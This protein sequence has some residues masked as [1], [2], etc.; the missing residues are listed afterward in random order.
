MGRKIQL[1]AGML[2]LCVLAA[3][4]AAAGP[5]VVWRLPE[6]APTTP[7]DLDAK[8]GWAALDADGPKPASLP[9]GLA[10]EGPGVLA[11]LPAGGR[12]IELLSKGTGRARYVRQRLALVGTGGR[13]AGPLGKLRLIERDPAAAAEVVEKWP[14]VT[15]YYT[16]RGAAASVV[17]GAWAAKAPKAAV[18]WA[19]RLVPVGDRLAA[20]RA[21]A[22]AWAANA[23]AEAHAWAAARRDR[24]EAVHALVGLAAGLRRAAGG[25]VTGPTARRS[26][27][28]AP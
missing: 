16:Y 27:P 12:A 9:G 19:S 21:A 24:R 7:A 26:S 11:V 22:A 14:G 3:V 17:A 28:P 8:R 5:F 10:V 18:A 1:A 20:F 15:D 25:G 6:R 2:V 13:R 23:P 4:G